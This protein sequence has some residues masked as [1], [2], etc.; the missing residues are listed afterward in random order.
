MQTT[1]QK[2]RERKWNG[3]RLMSSEKQFSFNMCLGVKDVHDIF[4]YQILFRFCFVFSF[5][6]CCWHLNQNLN[7]TESRV[8]VCTAQQSSFGHSSY[9]LVFLCSMYIFKEQVIRGRISLSLSLSLS[10][11]MRSHSHLVSA[12]SLPLRQMSR[13][14]S[15]YNLSRSNTVSSCQACQNITSVGLRSNTVSSSQAC[16]NITSAGLTL[17]ALARPVRI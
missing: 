8:S 6:C 4:F 2:L 17:L 1:D 10:A 16:Q 14:L 15:E 11:G 12:L 13:G 7:K 5:W 9:S 3:Q